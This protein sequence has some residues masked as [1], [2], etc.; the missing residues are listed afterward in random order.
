MIII[1]QHGAVLRLTKVN[2]DIIQIFDPEIVID[3]AYFFLPLR[4]ISRWCCS[5]KKRNR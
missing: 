4:S 2:E 1:F 5:L 3:N